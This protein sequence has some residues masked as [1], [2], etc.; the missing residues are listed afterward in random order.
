MN[1]TVEP[2]SLNDWEKYWNS[3]ELGI[4][5]KKV[6]HIIAKIPT[7]VK[8]PQLNRSFTILANFYE[9]T[10]LEVTGYLKQ[11]TGYEPD[12]VINGGIRFLFSLLHPEDVNKVAACAIYYQ[13]FIHKI[14]INKR[15]FI[16]ASLNFRMKNASGEYIR[17]LEHVT[18][19]DLN[20][21]GLV[22]H[23]LKHYTD[24]THLPF[25]DNVTLSFIDENLA[26]APVIHTV[27]ACSPTNYEVLKLS[28][29]ELEVLKIIAIGKTTKEIADIMNLSPDTVKN[30]RKNMLIKTGAKNISEVL[31][32]AF[33]NQILK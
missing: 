16:K 33:V 14:S 27:V 6:E 4:Q 2:I 29:R 5:S 18:P 15:P 12:A 13:E 20:S 17:I 9:L 24:I 8:S 22:T 32:L 19:L 31:S 23:C 25:T 3:R 7:S 10:C 26:D 21:Q 30:H 28:N 1:K 11:I